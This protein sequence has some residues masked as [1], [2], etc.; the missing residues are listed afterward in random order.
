MRLASYSRWLSQFAAFTSGGTLPTVAQAMRIPSEAVQNRIS[1][2]S[3]SSA[4]SAPP[5]RCT[6][7]R[8]G[9]RRAHRQEMARRYL[10]GGPRNLLEMGTRIERG[11]SAATGLVATPWAWARVP[12][13]PIA[14]LAE[15]RKPLLGIADPPLRD[16]T[17]SCIQLRVQSL[18]SRPPSSFAAFED[19]RC[20]SMP[21]AAKRTI[22]A[23]CRRRCSVLVERA[24]RSR[25]A[26][27]SIVKTT[28]VAPGMPLMHP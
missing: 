1:W 4:T 20:F 14:R 28:G 15:T 18:D 16:R 19:E 11:R 23:R 12:A 21:S 10:L 8:S 2:R 24:K 9:Q 5:K 26:R 22:R 25:S 17:R 6:A 7:A 13:P 27:S 3:P